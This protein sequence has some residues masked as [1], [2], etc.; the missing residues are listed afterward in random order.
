MAYGDG[1]GVES[2][3]LSQALDIVAH[4]LTHAVTDGTSGLVYFGQSGALNESYSDVF[5]IMVDTG[6]FQLGEDVWT[7]GTPGDALRDMADPTLYNQPANM[8]AFRYTLFDSSGV[9]INS[10]IPNKAA[11]LAITDPGYGIGRPAVQQIYYRALVN[12]LTPSSNFLANLNALIQASTDLFGAGSA[13]TAAIRKSQAAVGV[14]ASPAVTFPN[15]GETLTLGAP[16]NITWTSPGD[17]GI[18]WQVDALR[19]LGAVT[20]VQGFEGGAALPAGFTTGG[21]QPWTTD[22]VLPGAGTRSA[23][24]GTITDGQR[25]YLLYTATMTAPGNVSFLIKVSSEQNFDFF[26]FW[27]DGVPIAQGSGEI[28][29]STFTTGAPVS[30]GTHQFVFVYEKDGEL[31][32]GLDAAWIDNLTIPNSENVTFA[33]INGATAGGATSQSWTPNIAGTNY[34]IRLTLPGVAPWYAFDRSN[35]LFTVAGPALASSFYTLA[36]CRAA[37]TRDPNGPYGGPALDA[38]ISRTF[39][40]ANRCGIP[41][42]AK[43]V[44]LNVTIAGPT[45]LG[46]L[47]LYPGGTSLPIVST[48]NFRPGQTRANNAIIQLGAGGTLSTVSG[49]ASGTV[50]LLL[51]VNGYFE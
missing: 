24:S 33:T 42:T 37:D 39:T 7:P 46:H 1:D 3:P 13:Q 41:A 18:G 12:Y 29:W 31:S 48:M 23:R 14:A 32:A 6:D 26:S 9:H 36:P 17:A 38:G 28:P 49:Q 11:H 30:A 21:H 40:L 16:A 47:S 51:D 25:S 35:G 20:N 8:A 45:S 10:G 15:G 34:R 50:H 43:A 19:D 5:A 22:T 44:S 4:E 27:I 2:G